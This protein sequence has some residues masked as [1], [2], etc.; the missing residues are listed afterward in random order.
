MSFSLGEVSSIALVGWEIV[1]L[2]ETL[3]FFFFCFF[4]LN[5]TQQRIKK[6]KESLELM[7]FAKFLAPCQTNLNV[8]YCSLNFAR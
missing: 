6:T 8:G 7:N 4:F 2:F 1:V 3:L 5:L